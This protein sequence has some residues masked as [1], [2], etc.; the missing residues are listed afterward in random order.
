MQIG[1]RLQALLA[2]RC[3]LL[4]VHPR[5]GH[6][7][8]Q[9]TSLE[10]LHHNPQLVVHEE[11]A[12]RLDDVRV[13]VVSHDNNLIEQQLAALLLPQVHLLDGHL[14]TCRKKFLQFMSLPH[15]RNRYLPVDL[16]VAMQTVPVEPSPILVKFSRFS[17]GSPAETTICNAA[18]N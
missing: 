7:V 12:V 16:S 13:V 4:F 3:D 15:Q 1:Q 8:G 2:H 11:A 9:R 10:V 18:R 14:T 6:D 5:V 17:R